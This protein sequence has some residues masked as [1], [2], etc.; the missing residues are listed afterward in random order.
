M[1]QLQQLVQDK[2]GIGRQQQG[3]KNSRRRGLFS[4][5]AFTTCGQSA[6]NLVTRDLG[7]YNSGLRRSGHDSK[8][9]TGAIPNVI[10]DEVGV[11]SSDP[12]RVH[13]SSLVLKTRPGT[14]PNFPLLGWVSFFSAWR[15]RGGQRRA[16]TPP[17][18]ASPEML[19]PRCCSRCCSSGP[20]QPGERIATLSPCEIIRISDDH[21]R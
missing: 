17:V 11:A 21:V 10:D 20:P 16:R 7:N 13:E 8:K 4:G 12:L 2:G 1:V 6:V 5:L 15:P 14:F 18:F 3:V 19:L 9:G